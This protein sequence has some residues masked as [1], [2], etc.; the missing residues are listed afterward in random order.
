MERRSEVF[1]GRVHQ[2]RGV[3]RR[4]RQDRRARFTGSSAAVITARPA[5]SNVR[6]ARAR[7]VVRI[8]IIIAIIRINTATRCWSRGEARVVG[9]RRRR[10]SRR[11]C[12]WNRPTSTSPSWTP[13]RPTACTARWRREDRPTYRWDL[14]QATCC[15]IRIRRRT[16][17]PPAYS[18]AIIRW[19]SSRLLP[20]A[21]VVVYFPARFPMATSR[22]HNPNKER[23]GKQLFSLLLGIYFLFDR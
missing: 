18:R 23:L 5:W 6:G 2:V 22:S 8:T 21:A 10:T 14:C 9:Y 13:R 3:P 15:S 11:P 7:V 19:A 17:R 20:W 1:N 4:A 12:S 16:C